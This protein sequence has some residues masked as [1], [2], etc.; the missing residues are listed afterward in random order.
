MENDTSGTSPRPAKLLRTARHV[1]SQEAREMATEALEQAYQLL[2]KDRYDAR[3]TGMESIVHVTDI[4]C[5][6]EAVAQHAALVVLGADDDDNNSNHPP[7]LLLQQIHEDW[8]V[9]LIT[10]NHDKP[11]ENS[12]TS[13]TT[14]Q[15][16]VST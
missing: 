8:I 15:V 11:G 13:T 6:G 16:A 12:G 10:A 4:A 9:G 2:C 14:L 1:S 3:L 5:V 7:S